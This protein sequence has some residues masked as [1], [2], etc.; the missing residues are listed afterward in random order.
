MGIERGAT[1]YILKGADRQVLLAR[2]RGALRDKGSADRVVVRGRLRIDVAHGQAWL[3]DRVLKLERRPLSML[4]LLAGRTGE[5]VT[6]AEILEHVWGT[7][8]AGFEH[9][10]EQA[11]HEIR[12]AMQEPGWIETVRGIGYRFVTKG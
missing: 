11:A 7:R 8:Y 9:S 1:D 12:S 5:V 2:I 4:E 3:G 6:R 10:I